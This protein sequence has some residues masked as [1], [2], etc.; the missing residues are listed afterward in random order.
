MNHTRLNESQEYTARREELRLAEIEL[1]RHRERVASL[2]RQLPQG[3][4]VD[5][6]LFHE[7]PRRLDDV[8]DPV[9]TVQLSEL[10]TSPLRSLVIYHFMY[11][12]SQTTPCPMC[13]MWIDGFN[14]VAHHLA[15]NV[16]FAVAAAGK[17]GRTGGVV[18]VGCGEVFG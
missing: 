9:T 1:M 16:D 11:G 17:G 3:S 12:K 14:G 2:R 13:T 6:Y 10:F 15:E 4:A 5:D 7:G 8:D 18:A